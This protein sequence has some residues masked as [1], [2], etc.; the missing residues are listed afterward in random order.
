M[1]STHTARMSAC[2]HAR[3]HTHTIKVFRGQRL[4]TPLLREKQDKWRRLYLEDRPKG[5]ESP[6]RHTKGFQ[7]RQETVT[8]LD[9]NKYAAKALKQ[10]MK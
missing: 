2:V 4:N 7:Q 8:S 1:P 6:Y 9:T 5:K 3:A 10:P